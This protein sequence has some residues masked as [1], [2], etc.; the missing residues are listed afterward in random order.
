MTG[1]C[2][3]CVQTVLTY[4]C[5]HTPY[6]LSMSVHNTLPVRTGTR[7]LVASGPSGRLGQSTKRP[8][9]P[10]RFDLTAIGL[11]SSPSLRGEHDR[12]VDQNT[13][14]PCQ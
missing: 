13:Q 1:Q 3:D 2:A 4:V 6:T 14:V 8:L 12:G 7:P 11:N 10:R 5:T 9:A